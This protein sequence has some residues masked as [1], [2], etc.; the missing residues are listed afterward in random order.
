MF[1]VTK[2]AQTMKV[3][4]NRIASLLENLKGMNVPL[5]TQD[6]KDTQA[7]LL[8]QALELLRDEA[9]SLAV[10]NTKVLDEVQALSEQ[11]DVGNTPDNAVDKIVHYIR[12]TNV[13]Y[14][15]LTPEDVRK[16]LGLADE[17]AAH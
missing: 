7:A 3:Q 11:Y 9:H 14:G 12:E 16:K 15:N 4:A 5:K 13:M 10:E 1:L 6:G 17:Q 2:N 8:I